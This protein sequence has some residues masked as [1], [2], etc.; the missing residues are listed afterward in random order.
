LVAASAGSQAAQNI[1]AKMP[2]HRIQ[3]A[4]IEMVRNPDLF[5]AAIQRAPTPQARAEL[6]RQINAALVN[7]GIETGQDDEQPQERPLNALGQQSGSDDISQR[8]LNSGSGLPQR[9]ALAMG[10]AIPSY[11]GSSSPKASPA[12]RLALGSMGRPG[13]PNPQP[14]TVGL[15]DIVG[16]SLG[17]AGSPEF[18]AAG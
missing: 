9:K 8:S 10:R 11:Q 4:M 14:Q 16:R 15:V 6:Q 5:E 7:A 12:F 17:Y 13:A 18:V 3:E 1:F 2:A